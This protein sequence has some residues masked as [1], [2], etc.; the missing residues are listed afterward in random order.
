MAK[1]INLIFLA[2]MS[3]GGAS[4]YTCHLYRAL[5]EQGHTPRIFKLA[6]RTESKLR[7]FNY[8]L[9][10]QNLSIE[11]AL[12]Q[13][14][15][16][17]TLVTVAHWDKFEDVLVPL[18][19]TGAGL[20]I[21]DPAEPK[22]GM[23]EYLSQI[24]RKI[25]VI[26][27]A[28]VEGFNEHGVD[29]HYIPHPYTRIYSDTGFPTDMEKRRHAAAFSRVDWDKHTDIIIEANED[30]QEERKIHV[31]G[32]ENRLFTYHKIVE[33]FPNWRDNYYGLF[34]KAGNAGQKLARK[35]KFSVDLSIIVG[36]GGGTQYTFMEAW[37]AGCVQIIHT[38]W[39]R[40]DDPTM[41]SGVNC[42]AVNDAAELVARLN[43][44]VEAFQSTVVAGREL[45][46]E[47]ASANIVPH[48]ETY[49]K[50]LGTWEA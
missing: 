28:N 46:K 9:P 35:Y 40:E 14:R 45:L 10:Y 5:S 18:F 2:D 32:W 42:I 44:P 17:W 39:L 22:K 6:K 24:E 3:V 27:K 4:A 11:D 25:I 48:I 41:K 43:M 12:Y 47:R 26:R 19:E 31:W 49:F 36:D 34:P 33:R 30:L 20:V 37:D 16:H 21:H 38:D 29:C 7:S 15:N 8:G 23:L 50:E 13:T 1:T